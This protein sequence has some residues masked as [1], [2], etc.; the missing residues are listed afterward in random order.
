MGLRDLLGLVLE[1]FNGIVEYHK[2]RVATG[3]MAEVDLLRVQLE[4]DRVAV[5]YRNAAQTA[6]QSLIALQREMGRT[7]FPQITLADRLDEVRDIAVFDIAT[8]LQQRPE[9]EAARR[10][11]EQA[12]ANHRLQEALAKPD[13]EVSFG[14][15]RTAGHDTLMGIFNIPLPVRNRN[16]GAI[17]AA[18]ADIR[19]TEAN[20]RSTEALVRAEVESARSAYESRR[21]MLTEVLR[22]MRDRADEVARIGEAA[23]REGGIDLLRLLDAQRAR[24]DALTAWYQGLAEY[25]SSVTTLQ[26]VTGAPF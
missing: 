23:Y 3:A 9:M 11:I 5:T 10:S 22:P 20:L 18:S 21:R 2:N 8:V 4:H 13:P 17:A 26:I 12:R 16:Q 24:L 1:T 15:K 25:Q 6:A 7:E 19:V 14:Y